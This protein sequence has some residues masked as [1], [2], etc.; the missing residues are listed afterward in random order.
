[1]LTGDEPVAATDIERI[2]MAFFRAMPGPG[3]AAP[4]MRVWLDRRCAVAAL[5][6]GGVD[7]PVFG[8]F[9]QRGVR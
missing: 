6:V 1:M 8:M 7:N 5:D 3:G 2:T 9:L 4:F